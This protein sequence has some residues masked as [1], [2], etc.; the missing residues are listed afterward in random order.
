MLFDASTVA[1]VWE[2][3]AVRVEVA[4]YKSSIDTRMLIETIRASVQ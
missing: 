3:F 4:E 1:M 2:L